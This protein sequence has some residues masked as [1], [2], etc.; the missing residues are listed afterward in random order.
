MVLLSSEDPAI[1]FGDD[2]PLGYFVNVFLHE[3]GTMPRELPDI[4]LTVDTHLW[5]VID[6]EALQVQN[7]VTPRSHCLPNSSINYVNHT[8]QRVRA[9]RSTCKAVRMK[10]LVREACGCEEWRQPL[11]RWPLKNHQV[12]GSMSQGL[13]KA[14]EQLSCVEEVLISAD[15]AHLASCEQPCTRREY[16]CHSHFNSLNDHAYQSYIREVYQNAYISFLYNVCGGNRSHSSKETWRECQA[17]RQALTRVLKRHPI[18]FEPFGKNGSRESG[19][20]DNLWRFA[21]PNITAA[22]V[23]ISDEG[24]PIQKRMLNLRIR[25]STPQMR[26]D[27]ETEMRSLWTTLAQMGGAASFFAGFSFIVLGEVLDILYRI[28]RART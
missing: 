2:H 7:L 16:S 6:F 20:G 17:Q 26:V 21:Y 14:L 1:F 5:A 10:Q 11:D 25:S 3:E 18:N 28:F 13:V 27:V 12:C 9:D 22:K 24:S 4:V 15:D 19:G 8:G 23:N